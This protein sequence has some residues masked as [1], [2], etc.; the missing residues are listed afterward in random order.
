MRYI[1]Y[2]MKFTMFV[3]SNLGYQELLRKKT[4]IHIYF[5]PGLT[6]ALQVSVLF[7][8]GLFNILREVSVMIWTGGLLLSAWSFLESWKARSIQKETGCPPQADD[9][10]S[11]RKVRS[12]KQLIH[13]GRIVPGLEKGGGKQPAAGGISDSAGYFL[14]SYIRPGFLY[15]AVS[16]AVLLCY[17][18]GKRFTDYDN[19]SH[20]A[21]IVKQMLL[22]DRYPNFQDTTILFREYPPGSATYIYHVAS[23]IGQS[24]AVQM[25]AQAYMILVCLLPVFIYCK[26]NRALSLT[27]MFFATHFILI[28]NTRITEL[29]VDTLL[30]VAGMN[31]LLY[32]YIYSAAYRQKVTGSLEMYLA[33]FYLIQVA[34]IKNSGV[35]FCAAA[36]VWIVACGIMD[37]LKSRPHL[38]DVKARFLSGRSMRDLVRYPGGGIFTAFFAYVILL[39]WHRHCAYVYA[40]SEISKHA[41]T[42]ANY[43]AVAGSKTGEDIRTI[44]S[45]LLKFSVTWQ[46]IWYIFLALAAGGIIC[47]TAVKSCRRTFRRICIFSVL[48]FAAWQAGMILMYL[49]SMPV[50]EALNLSGVYRYCKTILLAVFYGTVLLYMKMISRIQWKKGRDTVCVLTVCAGFLLWQS[51]L[52][53]GFTTIFSYAPE[54]AERTWMEEVKSGYGVLPG[55]SYDI[56]VKQGDSTDYIYYMAKYVF[57]SEDVN[58]IPAASAGTLDA[59]AAGRYILVYDQENQNIKDWVAQNYPDQAGRALVVKE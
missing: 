36:T 43:K 33:V 19:F 10:T 54:A 56:L 40:G 37:A 29:L 47:Y 41:M 49:F 23:F 18:R 21:L 53:G 35:F 17:F 52:T 22:T 42:V 55:R 1:L 57:Q 25:F 34:L 32:L 12:V 28:Y 44:I 38:T 24:E 16:S 8:G 13:L 48:L 45:S 6:V 30:P 15:L 31:G 58:V 2:F 50:W 14:K 5:L 39:L 7:F 27:L 59:L 20:W 3:L 26:R 51:R 46:D 11:E 9:D 4:R